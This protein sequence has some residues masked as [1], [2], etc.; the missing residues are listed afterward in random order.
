MIRPTK[1]L[2]LDLSVLRAGAV[3]LTALRKSRV[4]PLFEFRSKLI[5][6]LG[7]DGELMFV[8]TVNFLYLIGRIEY[9]AR[10]DSFEYVEGIH[11]S[12]SVARS[13]L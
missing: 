12:A 9:H 1:H 4:M 3:M 5:T 11:S 8:P 10:T 2:D 13:E 7:S 6:T